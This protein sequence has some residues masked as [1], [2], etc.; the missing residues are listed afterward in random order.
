MKATHGGA[1]FKEL[2][3]NTRTAIL[4]S[5]TEIVPELEETIIHKGDTIG[6]AYLVTQ[7]ALRVYTLDLNGNEK[8]IYRVSS[9]QLCIFS[10]N[11]IFNKILY[12]AWVNNESSDTRIL[13][14]P[15]ATFKAL[16]E[17]EVSVRDYVV[18]S[19]STRIFDLMSSIEAATTQ[20]M[21]QRINSYLVRACSQERVLRTSHQRIAKELG[22]AREVVSRHLKK[23]EKSGFIRLSRMKITLLSPVE[24]SETL[25]KRPCR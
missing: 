12:P 23:L 13:S 14:I 3:E 22:T 21:G 10:I 16:Y 19:L 2:T 24:L 6:G 17:K 15:T 9:G 7:G 25:I 18:N 8:P 11:C 4:K 5:S 1:F 20:D